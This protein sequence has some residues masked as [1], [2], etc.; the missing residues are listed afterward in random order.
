MKTYT[1]KIEWWRE[2][3]GG[4]DYMDGED[5][6]SVQARNY[7]SAEKKLRERFNKA[8]KGWS[9]SRWFYIRELQE[10]RVLK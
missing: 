6:V 5:P 3:F 10:L 7:K 1:A 8:S 4:H 2:S 9:Q